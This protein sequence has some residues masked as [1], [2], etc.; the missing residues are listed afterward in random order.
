M[1]RIIKLIPEWK[2]SWRFFSTQAMMAAAALNA[3][4]L[5]LPQDLKVQL[6]DW[7]PTTVTILLMVLGL[8]GR[9]VLQMDREK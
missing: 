7:I 2:Q 4:W 8:V 1:K 5:E 6:P 9:L 3:V